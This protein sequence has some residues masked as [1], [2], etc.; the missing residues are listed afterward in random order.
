MTDIHKRL[1]A[2]L[3]EHGVNYRIIEHEHEGRSEE[4]SR[5]RG[6]HPSQAMKAIVVSVKG[7]G[8]G[9]RNALA[10]IPGN[11][12]L[13]MRALNAVLGAQKGSFASS[14]KA[15]ELTGCVMGAIPPFSFLND[16]KIVV[17]SKCK[18]NEEVCFNAGRLDRSIFMKFADYERIVQP[19]FAEISSSI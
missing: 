13:N 18:D 5:I 15:T 2:L 9:K 19:Q 14:D 6:N 17:D 10:I 12:R 4:I 1:V 3:D 8:L 16:L 11:Q 7:G